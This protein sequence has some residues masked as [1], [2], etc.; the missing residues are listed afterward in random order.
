M[1]WILRTEAT[2]RT[3]NRVPKGEEETDRRE[4]LLTTTQR[5]RV[6]LG[7][8]SLLQLIIRLDLQTQSVPSHHS[9]HRNTYPECKRLG[10]MI[11]EHLP[12]VTT[13]G[14]VGRED[15]LATERDVAPEL[16]PTMQADKER[17]PQGLVQPVRALPFALHFVHSVLRLIDLGCKL[18]NR[19]SLP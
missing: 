9:G 7:L 8:R 14:Q 6:L 11:E 5:L 4:R 19:G 3:P 2:Q 1:K 13:L 15:K 12:K 17:S 16:L 10:L 18:F